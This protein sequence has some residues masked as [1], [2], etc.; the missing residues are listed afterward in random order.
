MGRRRNNSIAGIDA[1]QQG[2]LLK[3]R[4]KLGICLGNIKV[5]ERKSPNV[6]DLFNYAFHVCGK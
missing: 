6:K 2:V 4:K 3:L 5:G 1:K